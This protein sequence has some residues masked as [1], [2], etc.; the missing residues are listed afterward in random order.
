MPSVDITPEVAAEVRERLKSVSDG[1]SVVGDGL[2]R[3]AEQMTARAAE[4]DEGPSD[5]MREKFTRFT[6]TDVVYLAFAMRNTAVAQAREGDIPAVGVFHTLTAALS[7]M[8]ARF[9]PSAVAERVNRIF[10]DEA[11]PD[12]VDNR[13]LRDGL[14]EDGGDDD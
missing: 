8:T 2:D 11:E 4:F 7:E 3:L 6:D 9:V 5:H 10:E 13:F 14:A 1:L 12:F